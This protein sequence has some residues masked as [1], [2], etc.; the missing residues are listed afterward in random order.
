MLF[1]LFLLVL[2]L[3]SLVSPVGDYWRY[4]KMLSD[5]RLNAP[6]DPAHSMVF[7]NL[8]YSAFVLVPV[9]DPVPMLAK[10]GNIDQGGLRSRNGYPPSTDG[11][12]LC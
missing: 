9:P 10:G 6:D 5:E 3:L 11:W 2:W 12:M 7:S 8:V 1:N 4:P